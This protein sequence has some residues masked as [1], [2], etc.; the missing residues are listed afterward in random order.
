MQILKLTLPLAGVLMASQALAHKV[1][2]GMS[3]P[4]PAVRPVLAQ[5]D[6]DPTALLIGIAGRSA[7]GTATMPVATLREAP[8]K[9]I[10]TSTHITRRH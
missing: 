1:L 10:R 9:S 2:R 7:P 8:S 4:A 3:T 5:T 6:T